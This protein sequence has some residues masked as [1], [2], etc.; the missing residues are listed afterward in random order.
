MDLSVTIYRMLP[1]VFHT[2]SNLWTQK[3][4]I[5]QIASKVAIAC[6]YRIFNS[7]NSASWDANK[8]LFRLT[9]TQTIFLLLLLLLLQYLFYFLLPCQVPHPVRLTRLSYLCTNSLY[10]Y[11]RLCNICNE[12][13]SLLNWNLQWAGVTNRLL[14]LLICGQQQKIQKWVDSY[15]AEELQ[16]GCIVHISDPSALPF[17]QY[18]LFGVIP[19]NT[20]QES[21]GW[22]SICLLLT[23][24]L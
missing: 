5:L 23:I 15:L 24:M 22:F 18:S 20:S 14:S 10:C 7:R 9:I 17:F 12:G 1:F 21:G 2:P 6:S 16:L 13:I 11:T 8:P 4:Q 19:K 3:Q